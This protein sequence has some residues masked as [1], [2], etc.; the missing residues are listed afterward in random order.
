MP[1]KKKAKQKAV[2]VFL[3]FKGFLSFLILHEVSIKPLTGEDLAKK[4]GARKGTI[5]TPGTIYPALKKLRAK[6][7]V[8]YTRFGR[9]K[10]YQLTEAGE[11]TLKE[12]YK[13]F[14]KYFYGLKKFIRRKNK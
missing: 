13:L 8:K 9:K 12:Q 1:K 2:P 4:I 7:L 6:K 11:I 5:L 14:S 3:E 10:V